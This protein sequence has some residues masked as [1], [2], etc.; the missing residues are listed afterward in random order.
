[1]GIQEEAIGRFSSSFAFASATLPSTSAPPSSLPN[2][3]AVPSSA[4]PASHPTC[5]TTHYSYTPVGFSTPPARSILLGITMVSSL[6]NFS[7]VRPNV[8]FPKF[9]KIRPPPS[10]PPPTVETDLGGTGAAP[11][12]ARASAGD[13]SQAA[14]PIVLKKTRVG[15]PPDVCSPWEAKAASHAGLSGFVITSPTQH[16]VPKYPRDVDVIHTFSDGRWGVHEYSRHPQIYIEQMTHL[17]CI[18][19]TASLPDIPDILFTTLRAVDHWAEDAG[20]AVH[21]LGLICE[22][23]RDQLRLAAES[24]LAWVDSLDD[25]NEHSRR[26]SVYLAMLLRQ[27]IDRMYYLPAVSTRS[28]AVAAHIQRISLELWGMKTYL[29]VVVPRM[30]SPLDYSHDVLDVVGG[31]LREGAVTQTWHR[32]GIPYWVLQALSTS[33]VVWN[34]VDESA[35]PFELSATECDPPILHRAGVLAGVTNLTGNWVS[36]MVMSVSKHIAGS[37]LSSLKLALAPELPVDEP[38]SS[39]R[40]HVEKSVISNAHLNMR[41]A[42]KAEDT[43]KLSR[44]QKRRLAAELRLAPVGATSAE[45]SESRLGPKP[46]AAGDTTHPS[47][48]LLLS[49]FVELSGVWEEALRAGSPVPQST[50]SALYFY[51]P[52]FL[53]DTVVS[54]S[55]LPKACEHADRAREDTKVHRYL[56]N[57]IRIRDFCR[58]RLFDVSMDNR[59]L[60]IGEWRAA[61]WGDYQPQSSV[62]AGGQGSD[63]RRAKRHLD[64]RNGIGA[65]FHKVAHMDSY[66][67]H[68]SVAF[69]DQNVGLL[70]IAENP[71]VRLALLWESHEI[72]F[73]AELLALDSLLVQKESWDEI[74]RWERELS[75]SQV[76]GPPSSAATVAAPLT[77][78]VRNFYWYTPP[79]EGWDS[80]RERLRSFAYVLTRWPDCPEV[81]I[82]GAKGALPEEQFREVQRRAVMFYVQTFILHYSRLPVPPIMFTVA[83]A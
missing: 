41:P 47:R 65:L 61:L 42:S 20:I 68:G 14:R 80:C 72:N 67:E 34:V 46:M 59:A 26:Y 18:P 31:F 36:N 79:Q 76:W 9:K 38:S 44:R 1:M 27:V 55:V 58:A 11:N 39:K 43:G 45:G 15:L 30:E 19:R 5:H 21:G 23:V 49:P 40:R 63:A 70:T 48:Q 73:R 69:E 7:D 54:K 56:H 75:V 24:A 22:E 35:L 12:A 28:I 6:N 66:D 29:T 77:T 37:R 53:L 25:A 71:N 64:E 32:I 51:P 74:H 57:L 52:P 83:L 82:Q 17:A 62:R 4:L 50:N 16:Y 13:V 3:F 8:K 33:L 2:P 10:T 60:T 81:I 78:K